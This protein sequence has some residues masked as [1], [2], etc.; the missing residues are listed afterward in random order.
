MWN[1]A[2]SWLAQ[3]SSLCRVSSKNAQ[4]GSIIWAEFVPL[5]LCIEQMWFWRWVRVA[6]WKM[7][8]LFC[9]GA[10][11]A[12]EP[13]MLASR[14]SP[15]FCPP[16]SHFPCL[17]QRNHSRGPILPA[18]VVTPSVPIKCIIRRTE[19]RFPVR[20][21]ISELESSAS[22]AC[23]GCPVTSV[24]PFDLSLSFHPQHMR[25]GLYGAESTQSRWGNSAVSSI[26]SS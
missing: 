12:V 21:L 23:I 4:T 9:V 7:W 8:L 14:V 22:R 16:A 11:G 15:P 24:H 6:Y 18:E 26:A 5:D 2:L 10:V 25:W 17:N 20:L 1:S 19:V 13:P 3:C